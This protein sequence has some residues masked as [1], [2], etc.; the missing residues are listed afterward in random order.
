MIIAKIKEEDKFRE[1]KLLNQSKSNNNITTSYSNSNLV[2]QSPSLSKINKAKSS[3]MPDL[4]NIESYLDKEKKVSVYCTAVANPHAFWVQISSESNDSLKKFN[5]QM[6][7]FY[8]NNSSTDLM[9]VSILKS[10][11]IISF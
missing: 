9:F 7:Q 11:L 10:K 8:S 2:G 3:E 4:I 6:N 1:K 5:N